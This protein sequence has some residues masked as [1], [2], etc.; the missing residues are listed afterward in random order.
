MGDCRI[1][2]LVNSSLLSSDRS[3]SA[4]A[5]VQREDKNASNWT[6][7]VNKIFSSDT[8]VREVVDEARVVLP[9]LHQQRQ[10]QEERAC[11]LLWDCTIHPPKDITDWP[12]SLYSE[13]KGL[14]SKTLFDAGWFPSGTLR[15]CRKS[16]GIPIT[17]TLQYDDHQYNL[18]TTIMDTTTT[19]SDSADAGTNQKQSVQLV[20]MQ[21]NDGPML[22]SQLL[23]SVTQRFDNESATTT[24]NNDSAEEALRQRRQYQQERQ[25]KEQS[26][27]QK[28]EAQIQRLEQKSSD[29]SK[30]K[31]VSDQVKR[32]LIK[33]RATGASSLKPQDRVY[34]QVAVLVDHDDSGEEAT[35]EFRYFSIQD[36]IARILSQF[37]KPKSKSTDASQMQSE[38]LVSKTDTTESN[39]NVVYRRLPNIMRVYEAIEQTLLQPDFNNIVIRW[40]NPSSSDELTMAEESEGEM[41]PESTEQ[42]PQAMAIDPPRSTSST[43]ALLSEVNSPNASTDNE[44]SSSQDPN[45]IV[46]TTLATLL[47]TMDEEEQKRGKKKS[48]PSSIKK[49]AKTVDKVRQMQI[50]S[51]AKGD[52]KRVKMEDRFFL[53]LVTVIQQQ[54]QCESSFVFLG[55]SDALGR[56]VRDCVKASL[57]K[58]KKEEDYELLVI[59][60]SNGDSNAQFRRLDNLSLTFQEAEAAQWIQPFGRLIIRF[61]S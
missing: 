14:K 33:S 39:N 41:Q 23:H 28:L 13:I 30:N 43:A 18:P 59:V 22:P 26:R 37:E 48:T 32:M 47:H 40:Y 24:G 29:K 21:Q 10:H 2:I 44:S 57:A 34:F 31:N 6:V 12:L 49:S 50:K 3:A 42:Q 15:V 16:D 60:S 52:A 35:Q 27:F 5:D 58:N 7:V 38:L 54:Q 20:G 61:Q 46:D 51:K 25:R 36:T 45:V 8:T 11:V 4:S 9:L 55:K 19:A 53:E 17:S 56:I 1:R